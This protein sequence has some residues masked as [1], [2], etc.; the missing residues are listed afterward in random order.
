MAQW[1]AAYDEE[2][3]IDH[4][5]IFDV[6]FPKGVHIIDFKDHPF[7]SLKEVIL[8]EACTITQLEDWKRNEKGIR[9]AQFMITHDQKLPLRKKKFVIKKGSWLPDPKRKKQIQFFCKYFFKC[10]YKG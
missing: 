7:N 10:V 9:T 2:E 3:N 6:Y 5:V 8:M 4:A 1:F